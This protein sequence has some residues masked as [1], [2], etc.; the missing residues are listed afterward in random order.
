L[1]RSCSS[2]RL[3]WHLN[4]EYFRLQQQKKA[5][6]T[7]ED[8][9]KTDQTQNGDATSLLTKPLNPTALAE[10]AKPAANGLESKRPTLL[11]CPHCDEMPGNDD[12][13]NLR[14]HIFHHYKEHWAERVRPGN[15]YMCQFHQH[16]TSSFCAKI[17]LPK[18][19]KPKL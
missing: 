4:Y 8:K 13:P 19:Y 14:L 5:A 17:L 12:A 9:S 18:N 6:T 11:E 1:Y 15:P 16:F 7:E 3:P 2:V 10:P